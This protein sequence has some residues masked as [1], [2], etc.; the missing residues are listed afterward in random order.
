MYK[1]LL[2]VV[3][4]CKFNSSLKCKKYI[5]HTLHIKYKNV[6]RATVTTTVTA[7]V[8]ATV[9]PTHPQHVTQHLSTLQ[10]CLM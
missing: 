9:T 10:Q 6:Y 8:T 2:V 5:L 1:Y 3:Y 7:T 4:Q